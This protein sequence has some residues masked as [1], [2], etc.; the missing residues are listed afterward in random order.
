MNTEVED[1]R[2]CS[3]KTNLGSDDKEQ[4][5]RQINDINENISA[6]ESRNTLAR[7]VVEIYQYERPP[8]A[9]TIDVILTYTRA[10]NLQHKIIKVPL[11]LLSLGYYALS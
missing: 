1:Q 2:H 9:N 5:R 11:P 3:T 10:G 7:V 6:M 8:P 4:V